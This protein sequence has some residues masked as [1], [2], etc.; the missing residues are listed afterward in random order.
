M[1]KKPYNTSREV[2]TRPEENK[3]KNSIILFILYF[4]ILFLVGY[5]LDKIAKNETGVTPQAFTYAFAFIF[6]ITMLLMVVYG[7]QGIG[8][9]YNDLP[10]LIFGSTSLTQLVLLLV[11]IL[12]IILVVYFFKVSTYV[13]IAISIMIVIVALAMIFNQLHSI[14]EKSIHNTTMKFVIEFIFFIP[15]LFNDILK[16]VLAQFKMTSSTTY[17]LLLIEFLLIFSYFYLPKLINKSLIGGTS[18][19]KLLQDKPYFINKGH[20]LNIASSK[21]FELESSKNSGY[22]TDELPHYYTDYAFSMWINMNPHKVSSTKEIDIFSYGYEESPNHTA[23]YKPKIVYSHSSASDQ[24]NSKDVY[25]I[26]F[27]EKKDNSLNS[28][29]INIPN[30]R[31]NHF[32][33]NYVNGQMVEL[34]INGGLERVFKFEE[35]ILM[36]NYDIA[37]QVLIGN[38]IK[39]GTNGAICSIVY[40]NKSLSSQKIA[41][42]YN[43]GLKTTPY[44]GIQQL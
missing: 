40:F 29:E 38:K 9:K 13:F 44:P 36:P 26:Y 12:I 32:V 37:D 17:I 34:W 8:N 4:L 39:T 28:F 16:W 14:F 33:F 30:Q 20:E 24:H 10:F 2:S 21:E 23:H 42:L 27:T 25:R 1:I 18:G 7:S 22:L 31:W 41:N 35:G 6:I 3:I 5:G 11:C 19:A 15:C 43:I